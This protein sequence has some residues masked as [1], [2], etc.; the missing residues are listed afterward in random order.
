M[1]FV[2]SIVPRMLSVAAIIAATTLF[3]QAAMAQRTTENVT[4][5]SSDAFGR[6]VGTEKSGLYSSDDVRGFD[7]VEAG[8]VR[9]EGLYFDLVDKISFRLIQGNTIRVGPAALGFPFPAP[10]GLVDYA[11]NKP[12]DSASYSATLEAGGSSIRGYGATFEVKQ[13]LE[14][15]RLGLAGGFGWRNTITAEGSHYD[16]ESAGALLAFR[17]Q[18]DVEALLFGGG[19]FVHGDNARPTLYLSGASGPPEMKRGMYLAQ[20]WTERNADT[21]QVGGMIGAPVAGLRLQAGLVW[22][23]KDTHSTFSDILTGVTPDG[24]AAGHRIVANLGDR[25]ASLSGEV[26]VSRQ[27]VSSGLNHRLVASLRGRSRDRRLGGSAAF[28]L[29]P[30]SLFERVTY[31]EPDVGARI[32]PK[33]KDAT[34]QMSF[35]LS[36]SLISSGGLVLDAGASVSS[37]KKSIDYPQAELVDPV[38]KDRPV[39]WNVGAAYRVLPGVSIYGGGASGQE[40]APIAPDNAVNRSEVPP[41]IITRQIEGGAKFELG[42]KLNL[43]TGVF[44]ITKPY[45]ALDSAFRFRDLGT[46]KNK[47]IEVSL[48]GS[49]APGLTLVAGSMFLDPKVSGEA[50]TAGLVGERPVGQVRRRSVL[51]LDWRAQ[52]G[53][54]PLSLDMALE[55]LSGRAGNSANLLK[56]PPREVLNL[57]GRYRFAI[58]KSTWLVRAQILNVFNKYGWNVSTSGGWSYIPQRS[59]S[60]QL[61]ADM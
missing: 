18:K 35:G 52:G 16:Y 29:G 49:L 8:N 59:L 38:V 26:R 46:L 43:V 45:I 21:W 10:T 6:T 27:W 15:E 56:A 19:L 7:P 5:Q 48:A 36:Y 30:T 25:D 13:P 61:V 23:E 37:Y 3:P 60:V 34:R 47:G 2:P 41:A 20:D 57:G 14:G 4:T 33:T 24:M 53:T 51:N 50:V 55:S 42:R 39:T 40:E 28:D 31:P 17:P 9:L 11:L 54:G 22:S 44:S 32:G 12:G 1:N 58:A